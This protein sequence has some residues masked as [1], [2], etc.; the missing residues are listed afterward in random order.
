MNKNE[1]GVRSQALDLLRFPLAIV[2]V[3][4]HVFNIVS[5]PFKGE[6]FDLSNFGLLMGIGAFVRSFFYGI[7]VPV[8]FFIAGYVFFLGINLTKETYLRKIQNRYKSLF[9]PYI[10]WN[11]VGIIMVF[12]P[13]FSFLHPLFPNYRL[14]DIKIS[15]SSFL[16]CFWMYDGS[17]VSRKVV[18]GYPIDGPLWFVRDLMIVALLTPIINLSFRKLGALL[19]IVSGVIWFCIPNMYSGHYYQLITAI[20]FFS[21]GGYMSFN[22]KDMVE[23]FKKYRIISYIVF[24]L[25]AILLMGYTY[26]FSTPAVIMESGFSGVIIYVKHIAIIAGLFFVYNVA[27]WSVEKL[28]YKSSKLLTSASFFIY[29]GHIMIIPIISKLIMLVIQPLSDCK[30]VLLYI[31]TDG[32]VCLS[33]LGAYL[34]MRRFSPCLLALF[35]GGRL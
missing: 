27:V 9:I 24:P 18:A 4:D 14:D 33:L 22:K 15:F 25:S 31:L 32:L 1:R 2:I 5:I 19:P 13:Y 21:F 34:L 8:Y 26:W 16:S 3:T 20:F 29:A 35:T 6:I 10:M 30:A 17:L 12:I 28:G 11:L 7:G 23:E